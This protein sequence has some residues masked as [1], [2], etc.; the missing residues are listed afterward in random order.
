METKRHDLAAWE[1]PT[2]SIDTQQK[3]NKKTKETSQYNFIT[4]ENERGGALRMRISLRREN[5]KAERGKNIN[6]K[7]EREV[8]TKA[9]TQKRLTQSCVY[10][11]LKCACVLQQVEERS[12]LRLG[13]V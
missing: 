9:P 10:L 3:Y 2:V 13:C 8:V 5:W 1:L 7:V 6:A 11:H 4:K 12:N